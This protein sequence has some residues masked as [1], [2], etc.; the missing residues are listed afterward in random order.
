MFAM[1]R[2]SDPRP[3][4]DGRWVLFSRVQYDIEANRGNTDLGLVSIDGKSELRLTR[5]P[6][7]DTNG[8]WLPDG[9]AVIFLSN[10]SGSFQI[11]RAS[12]SGG[13]PERLTDFPVDVDGF[14]LSPDGKRAVFWSAV[15]PD[16]P[17]L[18]CTQKRLQER[19]ASKASGRIFD[20][21]FV[22]HWDS[23]SDGRRNH[24][25]VTPLPPIEGQAPVDLMSGMDQDAPTRPFGGGEEIAWAPDG[26][27]VVFASRPGIHEAWST[28]VELYRVATDGKSRP[29]LLTDDN[30]ATDTRP[31]FSPDGKTLAYL[32]M[33]RPG[34]EADRLRI[35]LW[36][37]A[38]GKKTPLTQDW[39][40]SVEEMVW[41]HDGSVLYVTAQEHGRQKIFS[42]ESV[43][44]A[45]KPLHEIGRNFSLALTRAGTL[46]FLQ[47]RMTRPAEI[48]ELDPATGRISPVSHVNDER[49]RKIRMSEPEELWFENDGFRVHAWILR[50]V[51]AAKGKKVPLAFLIHGGPQGSWLDDFHYRWNPQFYA[52]AGYAVVA[53]DF[54]GSTGYGQAFVDAIRG[55]WGPGP[56]SDLMAGL[57]AAL[58]LLPEV[59]PNRMCAL[60]ASFG[61]YMVNWIAG[62]EHPF[63]CLVT[64]DGDFD[65]ESSYYNTE[66][67]WFPEWEMTGT[68]WEK[69][70]VY[71]RN[72]PKSY[73]NRWK[74]PTLVVQGGL[75][76]RVVETES[77]ST[78]NALQR[79]GVPSRLLHFPDENHWVL[80]P[81]NSRLWHQT[82]LE[83]LDRWTRTQ[84]KTG[85]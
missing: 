70:D 82:V 26:G 40:R 55:N 79:R 53:V 81:Q 3:S 21:L 25:F 74:T 28:N 34:F 64:H 80:K 41:A 67:L 15:F 50:P 68:P 7:V 19:A 57:K 42:V 13:D 22:R 63:A 49:L 10:R 54:R 51:D 37:A 73:V 29:V 76:F 45:V 2:L 85:H 12:L 46:C 66:E 71:A 72:S 20:R 39:D 48:F 43:S 56:F 16:C 8:R 83:W 61:G 59:D 17:D 18:S 30:P 4:P 32:A 58:K 14:E 35:V 1:V 75:D 11:W 77:L 5:D 84:R 52:G 38:S 69:A 6:A 65:T 47:D 60:G 31:V 78:F 36:D 9:T 33:E 27:S 44:G 23:W 62:Q 24:I